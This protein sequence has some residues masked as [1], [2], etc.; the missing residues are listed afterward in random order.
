MNNIN[1]REYTFN[2]KLNQFCIW[3]WGYLGD[4]SRGIIII[5]RKN[6]EGETEGQQQQVIEGVLNMQIR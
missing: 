6:L 4:C 1:R 3:A 5:Y 2:G